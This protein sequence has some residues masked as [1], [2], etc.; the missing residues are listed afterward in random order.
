MKSI[1]G[2]NAAL[3]I[4]VLWLG[5]FSGWTIG[6]V[7]LTLSGSSFSSIWIALLS[8]LACS[9]L[10]F[11]FRNQLASIVFLAPRV[12]GGIE[13]KTRTIKFV[14]ALCSMTILV[15]AV[16][17]VPTGDARPLFSACLLSS[18]VAL[19]ISKPDAQVD[20]E[21]Q[22]G[23]SLCSVSC[24]AIAIW[25]IYITVLRHDADDAFYLNLPIGII[26]APYGMLQWD[27]MYGTPE[28]PLLGSNYR[29][30]S[31]PTLTAAIAWGTGLPVVVVAHLVLPTIWCFVWAAT[32][33][34]LGVGLFARQWWIFAILVGLS[35]LAFAG[36]LQTWGVHG[37]SRLYHGKAPL[38]LIVVPLI[39][40]VVHRADVLNV[41]LRLSLGVATALT[42]VALGLTANSIYIGPLVLGLT[43]FA[44]WLER[45]FTSTRRLFVLIGSAPALLAGLWLVLW[46]M[47]VSVPEGAVSSLNDLG[48]WNVVPDKARLALLTL[49]IA[50]ASLGSVVVAK[51]RFASAFVVGS[52]VFV[53]NPL[54]W[55]FYE[56]AVTGGLNFRLWWALPIPFFLA[57]WLTSLVIQFKKM[58]W[59]LPVVVAALIAFSFTENGLLGMPGT[60][61]GVTFT[62]RPPNAVLVVEKVRSFSKYRKVLAPEEISAWLPT[63]GDGGVQV[64]VRRLYLAHSMAAL[65][66]EVVEPKRIL[67][68]WINA[69]GDVSESAVSDALYK[70]RVQV[71][72]VSSERLPAGFQNL[73][74]RF[75]AQLVDQVSG[76]SIYELN[77]D[78]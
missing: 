78:R 4:I 67:A 2:G 14:V 54:L 39:V 35:S 12:Q 52:L 41:P 61:F 11:R 51:A 50:I 71:L 76:Y 74:S 34:V 16:Y 21:P 75:N 44:G 63:M 66:S 1:V 33:G 48:V 20:W 62:K 32:L 6:S 17:F 31:L 25:L 64:Y 36:T 7:P 60:E 27:T 13:Q 45:G 47:P 68:D 23:P 5:F 18:V 77:L 22:Q 24:L 26:S 29:V 43:L 70:E 15:C 56:R 73:V 19:W 40:F 49:T 10:G 58:L 38:M 65:G 69:M 53:M 9:F 55:P 57:V 37:V 28:W 72:V 59:P 30:E 3:N 42:V 46:D 8:G